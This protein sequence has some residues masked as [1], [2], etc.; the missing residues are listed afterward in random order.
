M[1]TGSITLA[2]ELL[3]L[4]L[5]DELRLFIHPVVVGKGRGLF[6]DGVDIRDFALVEARAFSGGVVL[7]NYRRKDV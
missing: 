4:G 2:K 5:I 7:L 3:R 1:L 6:P